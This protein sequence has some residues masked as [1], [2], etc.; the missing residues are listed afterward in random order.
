MLPHAY[1]CLVAFCKPTNKQTFTR[2]LHLLAKLLIS[3][4]VYLEL[5][6]DPDKRNFWKFYV[7]YK[8][9]HLTVKKF[10]DSPLASQEHFDSYLHES[11]EQQ[12]SVS[13][14]LNPRDVQAGSR[15]LELRP[16]ILVF[17]SLTM[18]YFWKGDNEAEL[19]RQNFKGKTRLLMP[20]I[21]ILCRN[22]NLKKNQVVF[23]TIQL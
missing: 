13:G 17:Q 14:R 4:H 20:E 1:H 21:R 18:P 16:G 3:C 5:A 11:F 10:A 19:V 12:A 9:L 8:C 22:E 7:Y 2:P 15:W 23:I 6:L